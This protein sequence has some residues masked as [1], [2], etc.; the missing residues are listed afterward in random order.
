MRVSELARELE[1]KPN[2]IIELLAQMGVSEKKTFASSLEGGVVEAIRHCLKTNHAPTP[3]TRPSLEPRRELA[4]GSGLALRRAQVLR[5][6]A[7]ILGTNDPRAGEPTL[8]RP[9][10][11]PGFADVIRTQAHATE[12]G[13]SS[14]SSHPE[15]SGRVSPLG[16][17]RNYRAERGLDGSRDFWQFR[18]TGRFGSHSVYDDCGGESA[19]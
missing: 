8:R 9:L 16:E 15:H 1:V 10:R 18:E 7:A 11:P 19:P 17:V 4:I 13:D 5:R 12:K 6:R 3:A 2:L 14:R